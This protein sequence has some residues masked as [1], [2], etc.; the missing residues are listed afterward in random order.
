M[1][2]TDDFLKNKPKKWIAILTVLVFIV[3]FIFIPVSTE[4]ESSDTGRDKSGLQVHEADVVDVNA[5]KILM[6]KW[7]GGF[8]ACSAE[9]DISTQ[10]FE[11]AQGSYNTYGSKIKERMIQLKVDDDDVPENIM[12]YAKNCKAINLDD[13]DDWFKLTFKRYTEDKEFYWYGDSS[14]ELPKQAEGLLILDGETP[15][16]FEPYD[17]A[18]IK[19]LPD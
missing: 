16:L 9:Y 13:N 12:S 1:P 15:V 6:G 3:L 7:M 19:R 17:L 11:L 14:S 18:K 8:G 2:I 4:K 5:P 10:Y